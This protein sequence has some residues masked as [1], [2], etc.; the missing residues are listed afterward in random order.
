MLIVDLKGTCTRDGG[1]TT[2]TIEIGAARI[3]GAN[4]EYWSSFVRPII[5]PRLSDFCKTLTT[6]QQADVDTARKFPEAFSAFCRWAN[7]HR[8][9]SWGT[10]DRD[11]L[12]LDCET[13]LIQ[14]PF[15]NHIDLSRVFKIMA[16]HKCGHR[17]AMKHLGLIPDGTH[18]RGIDDVKNIARIAIAMVDRGWM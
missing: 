11:Q 7:T 9:Y 5:N 13:H 18:H 14:N 2:E 4:V 6:I 15:T 8:F 16:G 3:D 10:Y 1:I 17:R 12:R